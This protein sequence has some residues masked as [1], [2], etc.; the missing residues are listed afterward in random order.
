[1]YCTY[2]HSLYMF[3][4]HPRY[5]QG[6]DFS[7]GSMFTTQIGEVCPSSHTIYILRMLHMHIDFISK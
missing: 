7:E 4:A 3:L 2:V 1:M 6:C 5:G